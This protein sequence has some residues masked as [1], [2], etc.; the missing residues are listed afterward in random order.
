[1]GL[2]L[3]HVQQGTQG[4]HIVVRHLALPSGVRA[5]FLRILQLVHPRQHQHGG[6]A[7]VVA[8]EY[9]RVESGK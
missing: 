8:E 1:M 2:Y 9:V 7:A 5:P 3:Q 4:L 6:C